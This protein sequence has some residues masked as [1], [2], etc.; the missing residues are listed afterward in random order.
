MKVDIIILYWETRQK[1][2][3]RKGVN[4]EVPWIPVDLDRNIFTPGTW[5]QPINTRGNPF[6]VHYGEWEPIKVNVHFNIRMKP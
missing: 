4:S 1:N 5:N 2:S 6:D 3:H